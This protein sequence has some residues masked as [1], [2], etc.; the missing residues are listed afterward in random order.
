VRSGAL[1]ALLPAGLADDPA[2]AAGCGGF[3]AAVGA[4]RAKC[5][6]ATEVWRSVEV[7]QVTGGSGCERWAG[8]SNAPGGGVDLLEGGRA[9]L[10]QGERV[11]DI[12]GRP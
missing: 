9:D 1:P 4:R 8:V 6:R 7:V 12:T 2:G 10:H 5:R 11:G 3:G